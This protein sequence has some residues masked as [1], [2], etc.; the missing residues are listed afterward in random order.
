MLR[1]SN[2]GSLLR[3]IGCALMLLAP[4]VS[5]AADRTTPDSPPPRAMAVE[6]FAGIAQGQIEVQLIPSSSEK[7]MLLVTNK[8]DR[9]LSVQLP[10][11]M[12]AVPV[13]AQ[14]QG[15]FGAPFNN[16]L[17]QGNNGNNS[18]QPIGIGPGPGRNNNRMNRMLNPMMNIGVPNQ[19]MPNMLPQFQMNIPPEKVGK[20]RLPAVCL[21][22]GKPNPR[23]KIKYELR[24]LDSVTDASGV[25]EVCSL[26]GRG[27][28]PQR[29]A[30]LAAW[31]LANDMS[32]EKLTGLRKELILG[33]QPMYTLREIRAAQE[34][35]ENLAK[36]PD[37]P[38]REDSRTTIRQ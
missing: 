24:P 34:T 11:A 3:P 18:P 9:P 13:L 27:K 5:I 22:H 20:V 14:Q 21:A 17:N 23:P 2:T 37:Q 8:T 36:Q 7:C 33:N 1:I 4:A 15:Q 16:G 35:V 6:I 30:Q 19:G 26:L 25:A 28:I 31:H 32:W 38:R 10:P 29:V 12:A